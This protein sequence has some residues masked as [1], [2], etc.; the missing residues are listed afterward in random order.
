MKTSLWVVIA[1]EI[2]CV[3]LTRDNVTEVRDWL[4]NKGAKVFDHPG[5]HM[6]GFAGFWFAEDSGRERSPLFGDWVCLDRKRGTFRLIDEHVLPSL[7][8]RG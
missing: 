4:L 8:V 6:D 5:E 7:Y 1:P 3:Q 2:E